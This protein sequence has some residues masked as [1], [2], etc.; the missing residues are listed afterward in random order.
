M[1]GVGIPNFADRT[2]ITM[3]IPS[4]DEVGNEYKCILHKYFESIHID[5][6]YSG[7]L[8]LLVTDD[9]EPHQHSRSSYGYDSKRRFHDVH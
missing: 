1:S 2:P 7:L 5:I 3:W 8:I 4:S 6:V 9:V